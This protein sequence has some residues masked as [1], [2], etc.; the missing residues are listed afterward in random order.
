MDD[1]LSS[2]VS[3]SSESQPRFKYFGLDE[4]EENED[5]GM[6]VDLSPNALPF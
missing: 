6:A 2:V 3:T 4:G 5:V 1:W